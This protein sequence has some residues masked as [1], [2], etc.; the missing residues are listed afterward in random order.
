MYAMLCTRQD[1]SY[2]LS[3]TGRYQSNYGEAYWTIVKNIL[4]YLRR[5]KEVFLVFGGEEE[6]VVTGYTDASFQT[7]TDDS[8][9]Q[10]GFVFC[11]KIYSDYY[12]ITIV[13]CT[14]QKSLASDLLQQYVH[15]VV[16]AFLVFQQHVFIS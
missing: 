8:K 7:D 6:L 13:S 10:S 5:T 14:Y 16:H 12:L 3:A 9:S 15:Q 1:V 11:L 2:A 4:N